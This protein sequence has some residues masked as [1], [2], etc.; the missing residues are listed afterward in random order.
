MSKSLPLMWWTQNVRQMVRKEQT[1]G[2]SGSDDWKKFIPN[3][4]SDRIRKQLDLARVISYPRP[5]DRKRARML[6]SILYKRLREQADDEEDKWRTWLLHNSPL[7]FSAIRLQIPIVM[8]TD[9]AIESVGKDVSS[10]LREY[11][12]S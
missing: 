4:R 1:L 5:L 7:A 3:P 2:Q 6:I 10:M 8:A 11:I 12:R 9:M